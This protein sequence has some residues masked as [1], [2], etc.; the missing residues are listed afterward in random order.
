MDVRRCMDVADV[1]NVVDVRLDVRLD[2]Q[3]HGGD[4]R[5]VGRSR[6]G[7]TR[8]EWQIGTRRLGERG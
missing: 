3:R 2:V 8:H 1:V 5:W 6:L 7:G 4:E